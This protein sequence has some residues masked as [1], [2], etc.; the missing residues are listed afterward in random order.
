[1]ALM[2]ASGGLSNGKLA[3]A[4]AEVGDVL[5]GKTFYAGDKL[6]KAGTMPNNGAW[7][8]T[9]DLAGS[10]VIPQGYHNGSG[11]VSVKTHTYYAV[12]FM[13]GEAVGP[14]AV[15]H[16][17]NPNGTAE[18]ANCFGG[19]SAFGAFTFSGWGDSITVRY[20]KTLKVLSSSSFRHGH[21]AYSFGPSTGSTISAGTVRSYGGPGGGGFTAGA[22]NFGLFEEV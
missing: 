15:V 22:M 5:S 3:L 11:K 20:N 21:G 7:S 10:I 16:K 1:M 19:G 14:D 6:V 4:N 18:T 9:I 13:V 8:Y 12:F 2:T 17:L